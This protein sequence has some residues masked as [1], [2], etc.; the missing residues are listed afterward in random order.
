MIMHPSS[1][2]LS[3]YADGGLSTGRTSRI[4]AHLVRCRGCREEIAR[5]RTLGQ[6]ARDANVPEMR[7]SVAESIAA[8]RGSGAR[9]ILPVEDAPGSSRRWSWR[10][11]AAAVVA[12]G[13]VGLFTRPLVRRVAASEVSRLTFTPAH[14]A[15]GSRVAVRYAPSGALADEANLLL[16]ARYVPASANVIWN[17]DN[18]VPRGIVAATL[19]RNAEGVFSG[20]I[21]IP[22]SAV[23]AQFTVI[24][25]AGERIDNNEHQ[26]W[27]LQTSEADGRASFQG[28]LYAA[29]RR[30]QRTPNEFGRSAAESLIAIYPDSAQSWASLVSVEGSSRIPN[31]L[32]V[33]DA[34]ERRFAKLEKAMAK[35]TIVSAGEMSAMVSLASAVEDSAAADRWRNRLLV[36]YPADMRAIE[37]MYF[38]AFD[39]PRDSARGLLPAL[40]SAWIATPAAHRAVAELGLE[41][42][43]NAGDSTAIRRWV[44]RALEESIPGYVYWSAGAGRDSA[45]RMAIERSLRTQVRILQDDSGTAPSL[46]STRERDRLYRRALAAGSLGLLSQQLALDGRRVA[47]RDTLEIAITMAKGMCGFE[48][49]HRYRA[50]SDLAAGDTTAAERDLAIAAAARYSRTGPFGDSAAILLGAK[51]GAARWTALVDSA[52]AVE[53]SCTKAWA[54]P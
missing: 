27:Q 45:I 7:A 33:F 23:V 39:A 36:T 12:V 14:P 34:R 5:I 1:I 51:F 20:T 10:L 44:A 47:A 31:W 25:R 40:D 22:D 50:A 29:H 24:D 8:R 48:Y 21:T 28:L 53:G 17:F 43:L 54:T 52:R 35:R 42:A 6:S 9:V 13:I 18:D 41:V 38:H 30:I 16:L 32:S 15:P 37:V 2:T 49:L 26:L 46:R 19:E 3:R 11:V 4:A